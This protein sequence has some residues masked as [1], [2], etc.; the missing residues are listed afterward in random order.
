FTVRWRGSD[1]RLPGPRVAMARELETYGGALRSD[2]LRPDPAAVERDDLLAN[3][4]SQSRPA[5]ARRGQARLHKG[6]KYGF[7]LFRRYARPLVDDP[8]TRE[9][10]ILEQLDF[11][12]PLRG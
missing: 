4:K 8:D 3:G 11:D 12:R 1:I 6:F 5:S 10:V 2:I 7:Q 9:P